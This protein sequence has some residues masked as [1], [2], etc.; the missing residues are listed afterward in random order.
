VEGDGVIVTETVRS[1][2]V[3]GS[4]TVEACPDVTVTDRTTG[5]EP[6]YQTTE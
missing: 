4:V 3:A 5:T 6:A 1:I 2:A